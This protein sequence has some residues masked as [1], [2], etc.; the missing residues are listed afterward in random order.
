ME[1]CGQER[2]TNFCPECG[3]KLRTL[4]DLERLM[5]HL[6]ACKRRAISKNQEDATLKWEAFM[7]A[8][9]GNL[10]K[11]LAREIVESLTNIDAP[12]ED[13]AAEPSDD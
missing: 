8:I 10:P 11:P 3:T 4:T 9:H 2:T 13:Q 1:C 12:S 5:L 7:Q 6:I